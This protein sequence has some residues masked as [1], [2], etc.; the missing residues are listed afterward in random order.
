MEN[1]MK[2]IVCL[3]VCLF[4][5][6]SNAALIDFDNHSST[7]SLTGAVPESSVVTDDYINEGVVFG[8]SGVSAGV[9]VINNSNT[10]ST[11]NGACGLDV[12]G[13]IPSICTG[14]IYF[15][16]VSGASNAVTDFVSFVVGDS[17]GDLDGWIVNVFDI[18]DNLLESRA[19][20]STSNISQ[21]F[22]HSGMHSFHIDWTDIA[23]G[24]YLFDNLSFNDPVASSI[25]EPLSIMILG[26]GLV[27]IGFSRKKKSA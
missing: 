18:A 20:T 17:G 23:P 27:G 19:F 7:S 14:D 15:N 1:L 24:G 8:K 5:G 25:P 26:F 2:K 11:P 9:A 4:A 10:F 3:F 16:F 6:A 13:N 21:T 12:N 22:M